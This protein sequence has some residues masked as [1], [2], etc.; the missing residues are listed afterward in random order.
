[1]EIIERQNHSIDIHSDEHC[2]S[3]LGAD[4]AIAYPF[5]DL[6]IRNNHDHSFRFQFQIWE[7]TISLTVGG[8]GF[9]PKQEIA[10]QVLERGVQKVVYTKNRHNEL[11]A[12]SVYR[13]YAY[14]D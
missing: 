13:Q 10:Y 3:P 9:V 8:T 1:M 5:K 7:N 12:I 14:G 4:A 2:D 11:V 6:R